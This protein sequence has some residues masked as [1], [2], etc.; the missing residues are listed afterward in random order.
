VEGGLEVGRRCP[1]GGSTAPKG[2]W[3]G[4]RLESGPSEASGN[5]RGRDQAPHRF[6]TRLE[7]SACSDS[8]KDIPSCDARFAKRN[9]Y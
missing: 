5:E 3:I 4:R 2:G 9:V 7:H 8:Y 1:V 6:K